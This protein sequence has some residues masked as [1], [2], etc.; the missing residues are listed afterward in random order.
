MDKYEMR[1]KWFES[2]LLSES[3][4]ARWEQAEEGEEVKSF[5]R[6]GFSTRECLNCYLRMVKAGLEPLPCNFEQ[7]AAFKAT[8]EDCANLFKLVKLVEKYNR[9]RPYAP[10]KAIDRVC[11][12]IDNITAGNVIVNQERFTRALVDGFAVTIFWPYL[13]Q[14]KAS[15][16]IKIYGY[17]LN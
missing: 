14:K 7:A 6:F 12:A 17:G 2:V 1:S 4:R 11:A 13:E 8:A 10:S 16:S 3:F 9:L 15:L 5:Q